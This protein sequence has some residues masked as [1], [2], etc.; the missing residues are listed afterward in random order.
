MTY[1]EAGAP[2]GQ[3]SLP[4]AGCACLQAR[5]ASSR[6]LASYGA[7]HQWLR[8]ACALAVPSKTLYGMVPYQLKAK[9]KRPRPSQ[10]KT[11]RLRQRTLSSSVRAA[12]VPSPP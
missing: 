4:A 11:T 10:A 8:E 7:I 3:K 9:L 2:S 12:G 1:K 5:L 6:G